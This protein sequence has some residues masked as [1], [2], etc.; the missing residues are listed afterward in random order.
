MFIREYKQKTR[1]ERKSKTG[2]AHE[3]YRHVSVVCFLCDS[4]GAEFN[5][6]RGSMDPK[7]LNNNYFHVCS[8]CDSKRFAQ[9]KGV[10]R[11]QV[12][13]FHASSDLPIGK[14]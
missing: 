10:E 4:C 9:K 13:D 3:Y 12:W 5:R 6:L 14:L 11:K 1:H 8:N 7:R 2:I